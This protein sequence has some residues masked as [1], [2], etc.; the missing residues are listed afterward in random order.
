MLIGVVGI[1]LILSPSGE[2]VVSVSGESS[3]NSVESLDDSIS[4]EEGLHAG[5]VLSS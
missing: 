2:L 3:W 1:D 4:V 5:L